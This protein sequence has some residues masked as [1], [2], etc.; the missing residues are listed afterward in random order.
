MYDINFDMRWMKHP[1]FA[2]NK[3]ENQQDATC[4][5]AIETVSNATKKSC[6]M[7]LMV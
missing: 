1:N 5:V 4:E 7:N 2:N 3:H 6:K